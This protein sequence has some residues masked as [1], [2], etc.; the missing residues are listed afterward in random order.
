[1]HFVG[2]Y[3][4]LL[5]DDISHPLSFFTPHLRY[6]SEPSSPELLL[7]F[8]TLHHQ[9]IVPSNN[10]NHSFYKDPR[11]VLEARDHELV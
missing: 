2:R 7:L 3:R 8:F 1:M 4:G 9:P 6:K 5:H 10:L 11:F